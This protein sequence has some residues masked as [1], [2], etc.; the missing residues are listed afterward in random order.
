MR[1]TN[2]YLIF[3]GI[4]IILYGLLTPTLAGRSLLAQKDSPR[5]PDNTTKSLNTSRPTTGTLIIVSEPVGA[6]IYLDDQLLGKTT[7]QGYLDQPVKIRPGQHQLKVMLDEYETFLENVTIS[8]GKTKQIQVK[9]VAKFAMLWLENAGENVTIELNQRQLQTHEFSY[10]DNGLINIKTTPGDYTL[11]VLKDG[12][13]PFSSEIRLTNK[14]PL[15]VPVRFDYARGNITIRSLPGTRVYLDGTAYGS[16]PT[17]GQLLLKDLIVDKVYHLLLEC[18]GYEKDEQLI[19]VSKERDTLIEAHLTLSPT[20]IEFVDNFENELRFWDAP[21]EWSVKNGRLTVQGKTAGT[22]KSK[23]YC[24]AEIFF[25][26]QP[27]NSR[28]AAWIVRATDENNYYLFCLNG[29]EGRTPNKLQT[30]KCRNGQLNLDEPVIAPLPIPALQP[31][32]TYRVRIS[33]KGNVIEHWLIPSRT[34]EE[35]QIGIYKD[36]DNTFSCGN[37]GFIAPNDE[38]FQIHAFIITPLTK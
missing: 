4:L 9:M 28:G 3:T 2:Y 13:T 36:A 11:R 33:I 7:N 31:G 19:S 20:S 10:K 15:T 29:P 17:T 32:N 14:T 35:I 8:A 25:G 37:V 18:D 26:L 30:Y 24:D 27:L 38:Q 1:N 12:Y 22:P 5:V 21:K 34:G 23:R 16:V 6:E